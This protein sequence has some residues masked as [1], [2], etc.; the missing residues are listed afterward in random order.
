M[1]KK[2]KVCG[3]TVPNDAKFCPNCGGSDF[4]TNT[5]NLNQPIY[6]QNQY[7]QQPS[8]NQA[9]QAQVSQ[10]QPKKKKTGLIIG[11]VVVVL[12]V[13]AAIG[14]FAEKALQNQEYDGSDDYSYDSGDSTNDGYEE[15]PDKLYYSKGT[16]DGS[17]Y[18]NKWADIKFSLPEGFSDADVATYSAAENSNTEC[19][20]YFIADDTMSLIYIT[21]EKL[22]TFPLYD[23]EDYLD[24]A[25]KSLQGASGITYKTPNSYSTTTIGG[26]TYTKAECEFNNGNGDFSNTFYV[27]KLDKYMICISAISINPESNDALVSN[28]TSAK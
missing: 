21:Y 4:F 20:M 11:I 25:M 24:V 19:G 1:D 16:F 9:W 3:S 23:E 18:E 26:Y 7:N 17:V 15:I 8:A 12:L 27:R 2:C 6:N 13:L 5:P 22:P 14:F 10:N 28:I